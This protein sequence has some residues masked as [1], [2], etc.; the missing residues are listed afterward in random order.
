MRWPWVLTTLGSLG[1]NTGADIN[2]DASGHLYIID[3]SNQSLYSVS[4]TTGASTLVGSGNYGTIAGVAFT[5]GTMYAMQFSTG[6]GIYALNLS[7]GAAT[8][9]SSY[10]PSIIGSIDTAAAAISS[11]PEPSGFMLLGT[12]ALILIGM[13]L[14]GASKSRFVKGAVSA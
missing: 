11:V 14:H 12:V 7:T 5:D 6:N 9:V 8:L 3:N 10:T 4:P 13:R 2:G 1:F